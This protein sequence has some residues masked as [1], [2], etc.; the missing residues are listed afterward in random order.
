M[1]LL[2]KISGTFF[3][4]HG[5]VPRCGLSLRLVPCTNRSA[6]S[7]LVAPLAAATEVAASAAA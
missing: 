4:I 6:A 5:L 1:E 2:E 3:R 7:L